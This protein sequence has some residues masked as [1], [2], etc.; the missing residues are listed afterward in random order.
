MKL[1][2][3]EYFLEAA[4]QL[5]FTKA[6]KALYI[7][8]PALSKQIA[9]LEAELGAQLFIRNSRRVV[10]TAAGEQ[11]KQDLTAIRRELGRAVQRAG[12]IGKA[13]QRVARVG[14]F[15]GKINQDFLPLF[16]QRLQSV[17][18]AVR[19]SLQLG[20]FEE[21]R[22]ALEQDRIDIMLTLDKAFRPSDRYSIQRLT[23]RKGTLIFHKSLFPA[24]RLARLD[25]AAF[26]SLPLLVVAKLDAPVMYECTL[27]DLR[28]A[29]IDPPEII[30]VKNTTTLFTHLEMGY[31][32]T[33]M[34]EDVVKSSPCLSAFNLNLPH[35]E[36]WV[37]AVWKKNHA[38]AE[39]LM[40]GFGQAV[41]PETDACVTA[42]LD[43]HAVP[44]QTQ[45]SSPW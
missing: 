3:L 9:L 16:Y 32:Y 17:D 26:R 5:N 22:T 27:A 23:K 40:E 1:S 25:A 21:I 7:S 19:I 41:R 10:L 20:V 4:E 2:Q 42:V 6:A 45:P 36:S 34:F 35:M 24:E 31:G 12:E 33:I 14:C 30:E 13:D 29:G 15:D 37:I 11:F 44:G 38:V 18:P 8:Q 28:R 43:E 39:M